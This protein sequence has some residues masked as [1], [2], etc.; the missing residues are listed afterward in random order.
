MKCDHCKQEINEGQTMIPVT[1]DGD[2]VCSIECKSLWERKRDDF[3]N[4]I[5]TDDEK[6]EEWLDS[7]D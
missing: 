2:F 6:F 5:L 7:D 4:D 3:F 1:P